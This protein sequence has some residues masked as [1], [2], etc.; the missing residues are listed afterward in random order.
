VGRSS[1]HALTLPQ[2]PEPPQWA[3]VSRSIPAR[4]FLDEALDHFDLERGLFLRKCAARLVHHHSGDSKLDWRLE[5]VL[6][7][8]SVSLED[9]RPMPRR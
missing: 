2:R 7:D 8:S 1:K 6:Q 9:T 4:N 5:S 3:Q